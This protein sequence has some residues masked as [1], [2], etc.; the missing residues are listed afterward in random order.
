MALHVH[1]ANAQT[2]RQI[3]RAKLTNSRSLQGN[4][5]LLI[6]AKRICLIIA[7]CSLMNMA[8]MSNW[9]PSA[10]IRAAILY[11]LTENIALWH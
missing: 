8:G 9:R 2:T 3:P 11:Y 1:K 7:S 10:Q 5:V 4:G 6:L